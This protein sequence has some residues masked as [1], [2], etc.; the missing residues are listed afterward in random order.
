M[1]K[2]DKLSPKPLRLVPPF[3]QLLLPVLSMIH[4]VAIYLC[5]LLSLRAAGPS[6]VGWSEWMLERNTYAVLGPELL[7]EGRRH[8]L[9]SDV[10]GG[11]KVRLALDTSGRGDHGC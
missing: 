11:V 9:P 7:V 2:S 10:A 8:D 5:V 6:C 1:S 3:F 4:V